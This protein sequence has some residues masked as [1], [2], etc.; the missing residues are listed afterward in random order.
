MSKDKGITSSEPDGL[1]HY[2]SVE[3]ELKYLAGRVLTIIDSSHQ[4]PEQRKATKDLVKV[5][6]SGVFGELQRQA[7]NGEQ[8]HSVILDDYKDY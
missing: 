6:F 5:A 1:V 2:N 3:A 7:W 4:D 8:G